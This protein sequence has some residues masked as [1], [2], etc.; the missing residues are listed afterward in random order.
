[1]ARDI[2]LAFLCLPS[3]GDALRHM[4]AQ[5]RVSPARAVAPAA[6]AAL[7]IW[8]SGSEEGQLLAGVA[9]VCGIY[10]LVTAQQTRRVG[11]RMI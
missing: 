9:V 3:I 2:G 5:H 4:W 7:G 8:L 6:V 1:M 11:K 10:L